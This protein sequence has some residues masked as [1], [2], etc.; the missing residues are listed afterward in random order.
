MGAKGKSKRTCF[1]CEEIIKTKTPDFTGGK[2]HEIVQLFSMQH[3]IGDFHKDLYIKQ[4]EQLAYHRSCYKILGNHH[5]ADIR[6]RA[7]ESTTGD[8]ST[9]SDYAELFAFDTDGQIQNKF[10]DKNHSLSIEGCCLYCFIKQGNISS[11]L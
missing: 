4:I 9:R 5:V 10:F 6:H 1:L 2:L 3:M 8:I 7:F 11:F